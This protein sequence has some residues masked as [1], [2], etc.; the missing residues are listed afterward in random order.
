MED[1]GHHP[2][3]L[4]HVRTVMERGIKEG[5]GQCNGKIKRDDQSGEKGSK[6][7]SGAE[8]F[9]AGGG[10]ECRGSKSYGGPD[11]GGW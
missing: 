7:G 11:L 3:R 5:G 1:R 8:Q 9:G 6:E 10:A 4:G 2:Q